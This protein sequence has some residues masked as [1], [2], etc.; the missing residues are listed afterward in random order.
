MSSL[1]GSN[2]DAANLKEPVEVFGSGVGASSQ[3]DAIVAHCVVHIKLVDIPNCE[4]HIVFAAQTAALPRMRNS[5]GPD[6]YAMIRRHVADKLPNNGVEVTGAR[7]NIEEGHAT[8]ERQE[9]LQRLGV[10]VW[11]GEVQSPDTEWGVIVDTLTVAA[12]NPKVPAV[13]SLES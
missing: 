8:F 11:S 2:E 9:G 5:L 10:D 7:A 1:E 3:V 6:I 4:L 13:C 12:L